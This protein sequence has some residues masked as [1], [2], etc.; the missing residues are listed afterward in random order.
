M[1]EEL[2]WHWDPVDERI[3]TKKQYEAMGDEDEVKARLK[4]ILWEDW[5][6]LVENPVQGKHIGNDPDTNLPAY[7][8]DAFTDEELL[9][10]ER[11]ELERYLENTNT[12]T[13]LYLQQLMMPSSLSV[14]TAL[15]MSSEEFSQLHTKRIE[16]AARIKEID[17]RLNAE[18]AE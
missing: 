1:A 3:Y 11:A 14:A 6:A 9:A 5:M 17:G 15:E 8:E 18:V 4:D 2:I 10:Q 7:L 12:E 16:A 13:I